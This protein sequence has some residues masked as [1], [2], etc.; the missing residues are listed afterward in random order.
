MTAAA[1]VRCTKSYRKPSARKQSVL[2]VRPRVL[3]LAA[4]ASILFGC[5][6]THRDAGPAELDAVET[7]EVASDAPGEADDARVA[8]DPNDERSLEQRL[9]DASLAAQVKLALADEAELRRLDFEPEVRQGV[10]FLQGAV[11]SR[12][13]YSLAADVARRVPG[14]RSVQNRLE[15][16][17][18]EPAPAA[19]PDSLSEPSRAETTTEVPADADEQR[20]ASANA[21]ARP[22]APAAQTR[23][24]ESTAYHTVASGESLWEIAQKN[25]TTVAAIKRLNNMSGDRLRPGQRLRVK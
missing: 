24:E 25:G 3:M 11:P 15:A 5:E 23:E 2:F 6:V 21:S 7:P 16:P 10:V 12:T 19:A 4:V 9:Q 18:V 17:D 1:I 14:V 20:P 8:L 13:Q 22:E